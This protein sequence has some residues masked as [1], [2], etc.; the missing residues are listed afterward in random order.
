MVGLVLQIDEGEAFVGEG[1]GQGVPRIYIPCVISRHTNQRL[2]TSEE[3][4]GWQ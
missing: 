3:L 4:V 1:M 2:R